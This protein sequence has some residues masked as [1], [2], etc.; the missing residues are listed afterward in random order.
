MSWHYFPKIP[1]VGA[2]IIALYK[3]CKI[4]N[5]FEITIEE[6]DILNHKHH[7]EKW[8]YYDDFKKECE[9]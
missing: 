4:G 5:Y 3:G 8:C 6:N 7:L 2:H 1:E 9:K